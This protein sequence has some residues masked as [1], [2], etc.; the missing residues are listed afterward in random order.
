LGAGDDTLD[1]GDASSVTKD[2]TYNG[3]DGTD[4]LAFAASSDAKGL[5]DTTDKL[6]TRFTSFEVL[7]FGAVDESLDVSKFGAN[8]VNIAGDVSASDK[9]LSGF[10]SGATV[11]ISYAGDFTNSVAIGVTGATNANTPNDTLNLKLA[12]DL[13]SGDT[14]TYQLGVSGINL[15]TVAT[16]DADNSDNDTD[17]ADGYELVLAGA[18][19]VREITVT[20]DR[21]LT[22][23]ASS[24][25][26]VEGVELK[27]GAAAGDITF[28]GTNFADLITTG[29]GNDYIDGGN[30]VDT[31]NIAAGG[32]DTIVLATA[33]ADRDIITGFTTGDGA[34]AD[35]LAFALDGHAL[36]YK[37]VTV[38]RVAD[39][40][41]V[42]LADA[43]GG[44]NVLEL[45]FSA[46][47]GDLG[48]S[49]NGT[50]LM[51]ALATGGAATGITVTE[52]WKGFLVAYDNGN[53]YVY[54]A[55]A[56]GDTTLSASE[57]ALVGV[58][59]NVAV[60]SF[61]EGNFAAA[62]S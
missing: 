27:A 1:I 40:Q 50:E 3:G 46:E 8:Q 21:A 23:D 25:G 43:S 62:S 39:G 11:T 45:K 37:E 7:E 22:L 42:T 61:V 15:L 9:T 28:T 58:V 59:N 6:N 54:Y 13:A 44:N 33:A 34:E 5:V 10:T 49:T 57:I 47:N 29:K 52:G 35:M 2:D 53:A 55:D 24:F 18:E 19:N 31:I 60:G 14:F 36:G 48:A 30:G 26:G 32:K 16:S 51:K 20:G 12:A 56:D 41:A 4:T 17:S 38:S